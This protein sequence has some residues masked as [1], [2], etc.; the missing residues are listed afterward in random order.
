M[1]PNMFRI[2]CSIVMAVATLI[3]A[4]VA[5]QPKGRVLVVL[6][7]ANDL[8][9]R[10]GVRYRTGYYLNELAVPVRALVAAGYEPVFATPSGDP[11]TRDAHSDNASFFGGSAAQLEDAKR[12]VASFEGL[13]TPRTLAAVR[14]EGADR[15]VGIFVP[16][17]HAPMQDLLIDRDLGLLLADFHRDRK[18]TALIC[19]GPIAL[20]AAMPAAPAFRD[21][22]IA[23]DTARAQAAS[24]GWPYAGYRIA[25]FSTAEERN[26]EGGQLGGRVAFYPAEALAQAGG[27]VEVAGDWRRQVVQD[28]ELITGQNPFSDGE[29]SRLF[30]AALDRASVADRRHQAPVHRP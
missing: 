8:D 14:K 3:A 11:P 15:F 9:L 24:L 16:G 13:R 20:L 19:H 21:A 25:V 2:L 1:T 18:P 27:K 30:V 10:D 5:A 4:S 28:R 23:G 12:F 29:L 17:G 6:S 7:S 26:A 22:M